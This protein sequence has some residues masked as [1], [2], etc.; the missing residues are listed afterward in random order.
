MKVKTITYK[1]KTQSVKD[2]SLE[3]N[4]PISRIYLRLRFGWPAELV[5]SKR[6]FHFCNNYRVAKR[7]QEYNGYPTDYHSEKITTCC[8]KHSI[9][10]WA[11]SLTP[12]NEIADNPAKGNYYCTYKNTYYGDFV[13]GINPIC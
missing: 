7:M 4:I 11:I 5:L 13:Q 3:L 9:C 10:K 2:W 8:T 1:G 6:Y 12:W